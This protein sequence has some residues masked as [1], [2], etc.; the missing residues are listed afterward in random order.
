[1][2]STSSTFHSGQLLH[3]QALEYIDEL[4]GLL[5]QGSRPLG[6]DV[7]G[8]PQELIRVVYKLSWLRRKDTSSAPWRAQVSLVMVLLAAWEVS[9]ESSESRSAASQ[10]TATLYHSACSILAHTLLDRD[11]HASDPRI[12]SHVA[13]AVEAVTLFTPDHTPPLNLG[14]PLV[15]IGV[16]AADAVDLQVLRSPLLGL[17]RVSG[18]VGFQSALDF[19]SKAWG[20]GPGS[21]S[22]RGL[23][24]LFCEN[25]LQ[26]VH[27]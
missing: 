16:A 23:K 1:M 15:I 3:G 4:L 22:Y 19:I 18:L 27:V 9:Q 17:M 11:V 24:I 12:M 7:S 2:F 6:T 14:W 8:V 10:L 21:G 5:N 26:T 20:D 13:A 25:L